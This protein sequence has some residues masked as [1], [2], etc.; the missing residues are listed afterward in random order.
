MTN[1]Y[2]LFCRL[3]RENR[4]SLFR[5]AKGILKNDADAEDAV[6][7]ATVKAY[8]SFGKLRKIESFRSWIMKILVNESYTLLR[9]KP[10]TQPLADDIPDNGALTVSTVESIA[11]WNAIELLSD[12]FRTVTVLFYYED[13]SIREISNVLRIPIGTV[14]SR[15]SRAREKLKTLLTE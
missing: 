9:K 11:L 10:P 3:I 5:V 14:N 7:E 6:S 2:D 8:I 4:S 13:L 15:L 12:E 1:S